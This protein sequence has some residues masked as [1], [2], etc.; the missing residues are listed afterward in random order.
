[1]K[2]ERKH[3]RAPGK[4]KLNSG[5]CVGA[6]KLL[7][8]AAAA[9]SSSE[10]PQLLSP[11]EGVSLFTP[12]ATPAFRYLP[13]MLETSTKTQKSGAPQTFF[14]PRTTFVIP[15]ICVFRGV[16]DLRATRGRMCPTCD[17]I[18]KE[19]LLNV[20]PCVLAFLP[21]S[22]ACFFS[23]FSQ[24]QRDP[25][26]LHRQ[27]QRPGPGHQGRHQPRRRPH[28]LHPGHGGGRRLP[29]GQPLLDRHVS[30][31]LFFQILCASFVVH[32]CDW[33]VRW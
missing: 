15:S 22:L 21:S 12:V 10:S 28:G 23:F 27:G 26:D 14:A 1:M 6:G 17:G 33:S 11:K 8:A 7:A 32:T 30:T 25:V 18:G 16:S 3:Y 13:Q 20:S 5:F 9:S 24:R 31:I 4:L 29:E 19:V 2:P